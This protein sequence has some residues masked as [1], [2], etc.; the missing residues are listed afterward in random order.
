MATGACDSIIVVT[1]APDIGSDDIDTLRAPRSLPNNWHAGKRR[2]VPRGPR[3]W[4][5]I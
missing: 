1:P 2:F 3:R 5:R 4:W